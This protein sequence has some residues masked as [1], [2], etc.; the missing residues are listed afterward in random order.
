MDRG[1]ADDLDELLDEQVAYY[2]ARASEYDATSWVGEPG[3]AE[4]LA[5]LRRFGPRGRVLELACG[6]GHWTAELARH[7]DVL[8]AVDAA[9]E[10]LALARER[11]G[12]GVRWQCADLFAWRPRERYDVVFF[13]AWLSHVPPQRFEAFWTVVAECLRPGGRV[14][15]IDET[16]AGAAGERVAADAPAP[17]VQRTLAD[18]ACFRAVKVFYEPAALQRRLAALG[19]Q[20]RVWPVAGRF[21]CAT[22]TRARMAGVSGDR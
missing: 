2:R 4:L 11:V 16:P 15:V 21:F 6:T 20:A 19:W 8:T 10:A 18:G 14:F 13:S 22:A 12:E 7:A 3:E 9:P 17:V 5:A 1:A